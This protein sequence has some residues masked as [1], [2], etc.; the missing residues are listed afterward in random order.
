M[1]HHN[2]FLCMLHLSLQKYRN[3]DLF[4]KALFGELYQA[5]TFS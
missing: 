2:F 5:D 1:E 4:I 3:T